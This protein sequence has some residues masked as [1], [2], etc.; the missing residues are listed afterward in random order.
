MLKGISPIVNADLLWV[1]AAMGHGDELV[2]VDRNFPA[3]S[4]A[5]ETRSGRLISLDG[6]NATE[7]AA[8]I[9][10][11]FPLDSFV[12]APIRRM[13]AVGEPDSLFDVHREMA[14]VAEAAEGGPIAMGSLERHAFY[15]EARR[16]FAVVQTT[17]SRPYGC[18]LLKKGVVFD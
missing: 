17:E 11:L 18:F 12:E 15:A 14:R 5:L 10:A 2:L 13:E 8:A 3:R 4:V 16:A 7:A 9:F 1:L 6:V